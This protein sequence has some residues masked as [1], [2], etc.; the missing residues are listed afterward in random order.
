MRGLQSITR[1]S[2]VLNK[3]SMN[4]LEGEGFIFV[5]VCSIILEKPDAGVIMCVC[6]CGGVIGCVAG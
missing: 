2:V 4:E 5:S 6:V 3:D 1:S